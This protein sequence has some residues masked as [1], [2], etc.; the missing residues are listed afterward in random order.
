MSQ[1]IILILRAGFKEIT[2]PE[3]CPAAITKGQQLFGHVFNVEETKICTFFCLL[4]W[5]PRI[6]CFDRWIYLSQRSLRLGDI[7]SIASSCYRTDKI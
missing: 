5:W 4:S 7:W 2:G 1:K 6:S 3:F